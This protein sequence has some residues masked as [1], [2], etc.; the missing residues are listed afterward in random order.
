MKEYAKRKMTAILSV[1]VKGYRRLMQD[2]DLR[3]RSGHYNP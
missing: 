3:S 2:D 1:D